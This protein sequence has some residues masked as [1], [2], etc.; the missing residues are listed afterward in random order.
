MTSL[1]KRLL[2]SAEEVGR[3]EAAASAETETVRR[4][5]RKLEA[6]DPDRAR[7]IAAFAFVLAR[8]ANADMN[9]SAEETVRM[10]Q[11][12]QEVGRLPEEQAV[13]VVQIAKSQQLLAGGTENFI[14]TR[15][16]DGI[17]DRAQKEQLLHC[18]FAVSAA[19]DAITLAEENVIRAIATEL[20]FSHRDFSAIRSE[21]NDKRTVLRDLPGQQS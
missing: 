20:G 17:A 21:Y 7:Y 16:L 1:I 12:V 10:E 14:V 11:I 6:M 13:L 8:V 18:L 9:I 3:H 4:I 2:Q 19:D 5:V 15:E